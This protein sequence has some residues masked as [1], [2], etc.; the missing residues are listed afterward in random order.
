MITFSWPQKTHLHCSPKNAGYHGIL[1]GSLAVQS[2]GQ[3]REYQPLRIQLP[4]A[5]GGDSPCPRPSFLSK[6]CWLQGKWSLPISIETVPLLC[7]S[8]LGSVFSDCSSFSPQG[9]SCH[10][11]P[12]VLPFCLQPW[13]F[14]DLPRGRSWAGVYITQKWFHQ[15]KSWQMDPSFLQTSGCYLPLASVARETPLHP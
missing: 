7:G 10:L 1:Q 15:Q 13:W 6:C 14:A 8:L 3:D 5:C 11:L 4:L 2:N 12:Y 9:T